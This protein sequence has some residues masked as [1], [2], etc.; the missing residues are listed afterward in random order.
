LDTLLGN[1][2]LDTKSIIFIDEPEAAL[3]PSAVAKFLDII[4][5]LADSGIQFLLQAIHIL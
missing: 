4:T 5:N 3:H 2:Y 1:R